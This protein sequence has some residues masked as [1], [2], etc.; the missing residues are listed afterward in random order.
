MGEGLAVIQEPLEA[1]PCNA[2]AEQALLA[3]IILKPSLMDDFA[4]LRADDFFWIPH[5]D[6][7][8]YVKEARANLE[9][10]HPIPM[11][12]A[13]QNAPG[14]E[15]AEEG[16]VAYIQRIVS[17]S[18]VMPR[19]WV[20]GL[21]NSIHRLARQRDIIAIGEKIQSDAATLPRGDSLGSMQSRAISALR[22][23]TPEVKPPTMFDA[24]D[25][26]S[27]LLTRDLAAIAR[28]AVP[29]GLEELD[30]KL[31][32]FLPGRLYVF[33]AR[34]GMG[35]SSVVA[36]FGTTMALQGYGVLIIAL[37]MS[38][39]EM[40]AR[41]ISDHVRRGHNWTLPYS[42]ILKRGSSLTGTDALKAVT[43]A[44]EMRAWPLYVD[45]GGG[46]TV[47]DIAATIRDARAAL[48]A[49]G[50]DLKAVFIDHIQHVKP[51]RDLKNKVAETSE[52]SND[53]LTL[54]KA[55]K[56][57][58]IL[59][60]QLNRGVEGQG[61]GDKRPTMADIRESGTIEQDAHAV[62]L[63]YRPEYYAEKGEPDRAY[64][65][66]KWAE[67]DAKR[68]EVENLLELIVDKNRGGPTGTVRAKVYINTS[69]VVDE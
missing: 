3:E 12:L 23:V 53:L 50:C 61:R 60:S 25:T 52:V 49:K 4:F 18:E 69:T 7:Y 58:F 21:A 41:I 1:Y 59:C 40:T 17:E 5:R 24:G 45:D 66:A 42:V 14:W 27:G 32:G 34:P 15:I 54:A 33:A 13:M 48:A 57:P 26:A 64:E 46:K 8:A 67:W 63:V 11:G 65:P 47:A 36:S 62:I 51:S 16:A 28:E 68:K 29:C 35:K 37:E 10:V 19:N 43:A 38:A 22:G 2:P 55:E 20:K 44:D 6:I 39:E 30:E 56:L 9:P 31:G